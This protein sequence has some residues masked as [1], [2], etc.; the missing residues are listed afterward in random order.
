MSYWHEWHSWTWPAGIV[1][2]LGITFVI[3]YVIPPRYP[4]PWRRRPSA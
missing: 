4:L 2:G 1:I 3:W